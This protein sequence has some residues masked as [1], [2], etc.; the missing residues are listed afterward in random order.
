MVP[1]T[2]PAPTIAF[3]WNGLP[4]YAA[5]QIRSAIDRLGQDCIVVGSKPSVPVDGMEKVL[6]CRVDWVDANKPTTWQAMGHP[7]PNVYVQS[8]W[9][10]PAF[11]ALGAQVKAK[12]GRVIGLSDANWRG[13]FRQLVLGPVAFRARHRAQFDAMM[14]PGRQ[15]VRLMKWFGVAPSRIKTGMYDADPA[16]FR[17]GPPLSTRPKT[18]LFVGQFIARKDVL[19]LANAFI[20]FSADHPEWTLRLCGSGPQ[21]ALIP[22]HPRI[23]VEN[24]VQPEQLC[25]RF[26]EARFLVLPSLVEAW[27][28]VVHEAASSGCGLILSDAIGSGDDLAEAGNAVRF[29]AGNGGDLM[30]ALT[31]AAAFSD[32]QLTVAEAISLRLAAQFSPDRFAGEVGGLIAELSNGQGVE[33]KW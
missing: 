15:G 29:K 5:R 10:Y 7:V 8:G 26:H 24:F 2:K 21:R 31:R 27:G 13:D 33:V 14:V 20:Q 25:Q 1:A 30:R 17:P 28:L 23:V 4:Q 3:S 18:F 19:G 32:R 16:L 9:S 11:S 22:T 12:G 6:G